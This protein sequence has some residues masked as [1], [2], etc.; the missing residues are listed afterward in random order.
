[1]TAVPQLRSPRFL[2]A[3]VAGQ[4]AVLAVWSSLA[5]QAAAQ[6][7]DLHYRHNAMMTPGAIGSWQLRRGG[8]LPGFYQPVEIKAPPGALISLAVA[9]G[10]ERPQPA[11]RNV[12]LLIAPVYRLKVANIPNHVGEE[13]FPTIEVIDRI[14]APYGST[15]RFPI[16]IELSQEDLE[17]AV[18]GRFVTRVVYL[19]D[20]HQALPVNEDPARQS[21][22]DTLPGEDP[23]RV[24]DELG[25]PVA[26]VR[27]GARLP[28]NPAHPSEQFLYGSP[29][30][31]AFPMS[32][33]Q[34][35]AR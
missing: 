12:G 14:Y 6:R 2:R 17:L 13:V 7:P 24:A 31:A 15:R 21:F 9:G 20:P 27:M 1:M 19:E 35:P 3:I 23:L 10:F 28:D 32:N 18:S 8:P 16:V 25:R 11:P 5:P 4:M 34:P 33:R 26:I 30:F 22:F 29:P